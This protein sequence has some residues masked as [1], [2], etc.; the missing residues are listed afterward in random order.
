MKVF[1]ENGSSLH[2][3][4]NFLQIYA[5]LNELLGVPVSVGAENLTWALMKFSDSESCDLGSTKGEFL[6]ESFSKLN[7]A[8]SLMHECFEPMKEPFSNRDIM[9]DV[10]FSRWLEIL[11]LQYMVLMFYYNT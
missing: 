9:E 5:G 10:I 11:I 1:Q 2:S 7:V 8:L 3:S 4:V 6:A